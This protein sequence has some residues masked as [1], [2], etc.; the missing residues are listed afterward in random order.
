MVRRRRTLRWL[1][2]LMLVCSSVGHVATQTHAQARGAQV[3]SAA[4]QGTFE[5]AA[6]EFGVPANVLLAVSYNLTRWE[7][8]GGAP[9]VAGGYGLM[10]LTQLDQM[11]TNNDRGDD[12]Q[13]ARMADP[14]D[15]SAHT[16]NRAATLLGVDSDLL[17]HDPAQNLRGGAVLLAQYAQETVGAVP[18]NEADWYGAVAKYSGSQ[19]AVVALDF[20]DAVYATMQQGAVRITS[21]G[22]RVALAAQN[23]RPNTKTVRSLHL[24]NT[25][26]STI[27]CPKGLDCKYVL[28]AYHWNNLDDVTDYGNFDLANRPADGLDIQYIVIHNTEIAYNTTLQGFQRPTAYVSGHYVVRAQDGQVAQMV[29]NKNVA[30]HAGNWYFNMHAIGVEHEGVAIEGAT[31]YTEQ[32]YRASARLVRYLAARYNIPLDRA[33]IIGHD[34]IPGP[35]PTQQAGHALGPRPVLGLGTLHAASGH[36]NRRGRRADW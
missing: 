4:L 10:H 23:I 14:N 25:Q 11:Q 21:T 15:L 2:F 13:R 8:H 1:L 6:R 18:A 33:H 36:A 17:K 7:D 26:H 5:A 35:T 30:W 28:A 32:M 31:W 3:D 24:R 20:A 19:D 22:Q 29:R 16:L 34:E 27:D 9:S 12:V